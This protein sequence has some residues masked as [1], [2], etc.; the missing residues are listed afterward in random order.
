M[1]GK[2]PSREE[3][4][5]W[6]GAMRDVK[7]WRKSGP[8]PEETP[9]PPARQKK[10]PTRRPS[11]AKPAPPPVPEAAK[12]VLTPGAVIGVDRRLADRLKRGRLPIDGTFDLHGL[13]QSEAHAAV[14]AFVARSVERGRRTLLIVTGKG[15]RESGG[16]VL[17]SALPRWLNEPP[18]REDILALTQARPEHGGSGAFYV[19]LRRR[20]RAS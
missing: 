9:V 4:E 8:E 1:P 12:P 11:T 20:K 3:R 5:L 17:K 6:R 16:G 10:E 18:L 7:A 13:T 2:R 19:L 14:Q 15:R